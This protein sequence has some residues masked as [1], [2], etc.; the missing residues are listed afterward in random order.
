ME[1]NGR[2]TNNIKHH[3][4]REQFNGN[5]RKVVGG[6]IKWVKGVKGTLVGGN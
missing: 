1:S 5:Q 2:K 6:W 3:R 4:Y